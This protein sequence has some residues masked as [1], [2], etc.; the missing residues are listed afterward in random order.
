MD[1][2]LILSRADDK[3]FGTID[4]KLGTENLTDFK[5]I[6]NDDKELIE[7]I[8]SKEDTDFNRDYVLEIAQKEK[9]IL[10]S[11]RYKFENNIK[12]I[13]LWLMLKE[14]RK[15]QYVRNERSMLRSIEPLEQEF[16]KPFWEFTEEEAE[17]TGTA[18]GKTRNPHSVV[19]VFSGIA[20]F[21][22]HLNVFFKKYDRPQVENVWR[23]ANKRESKSIGN[24]AVRNYKKNKFITRPRLMSILSKTDDPSAAAIAL[25]VYKGVKL[26]ED[27]EVYLTE[28]SMIRQKDIF[29]D[30]IQLHGEYERKIHL[31]SVEMNIIVRA[32][33]MHEGR[34]LF[35]PKKFTQNNGEHPIKRWALLKRLKS[36]D[37]EDPMT[38]FN[39]SNLRSSGLINYVNNQLVN[40]YG[41]VD[42]E[43]KILRSVIYAG[44]EDFGYYTREQLNKTITDEE[45]DSMVYQMVRRIINERN[46]YMKLRK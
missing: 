10:M 25:L 43:D 6:V 22:D 35:G 46:Q 1:Q 34:Y 33:N 21:L 2:Y 29:D 3:K 45:R 41:S 11:S 9:K 36:L 12:Q 23:K 27:R 17:K 14:G 40:M 26:E 13:L 30:Y 37:P 32:A 19:T 28:M 8:F 24:V 20:L 39:Y 31:N 44:L 16:Q 18:L 38:P 4:L 5:L 15:E 7:R 42:V